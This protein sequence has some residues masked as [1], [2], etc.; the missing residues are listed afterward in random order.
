MTR[1]KTDPIIADRIRQLLDMN[2][3][4][5]RIIRQLLTQNIK[6]SK[7][8]IS[9]IKNPVKKSVKNK[10]NKSKINNK[11]KVL[12]TRKLNLWLPLKV[13]YRGYGDVCPKNSLTIH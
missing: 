9:D 3:S 5:S 7:H 4:Y 6:V 2:W 11:Q 8:L 13:L 1:R 10:E 12:N